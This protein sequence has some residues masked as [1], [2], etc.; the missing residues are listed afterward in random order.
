MTFNRSVDLHTAA[1]LSF[2][3]LP[4]AQAIVTA[5]MGASSAGQVLIQG[6]EGTLTVKGVAVACAQVSFFLFLYR[7]DLWLKSLLL[8]RPSGYVIKTNDGKEEAFDF[9]I[10]TPGL[11]MV[12]GFVF[13]SSTISNS[14]LV[15]LQ[16][17]FEA[18]EVARQIFAN[19]TESSRNSHQTSIR[20]ME[21]LD[22]MR[23]QGGL[24][25]PHDIERV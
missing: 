17:C 12:R 9:P 18:D 8:Y 22:E 24:G 11:G 21:I 5:S 25:F 1:V 4:G 6:S 14:P 19:Q 10:P 20:V 2:E 16:Q 23:K 7:S 3:E 13:L 15:P